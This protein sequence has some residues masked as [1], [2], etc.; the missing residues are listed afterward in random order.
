MRSSAIWNPKGNAL[1]PW[2]YSLSSPR[3]IFL[4]VT[5]WSR[6]KSPA[7]L[8]IVLEIANEG[9]DPSAICRRKVSSRLDRDLSPDPYR[10][11]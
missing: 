8:G 6:R 1:V 7:S 4:S 2:R 11:I 3:A 10:S 9:R 5:E